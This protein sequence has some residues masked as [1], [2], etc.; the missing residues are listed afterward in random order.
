[1]FFQKNTALGLDNFFW[2]IQFKTFNIGCIQFNKI[3]IQL[4]NVTDL[5]NCMLASQVLRFVVFSSD[6]ESSHRF[7][8]RSSQGF[9]MRL[10]YEI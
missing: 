6:T 1:M 9:G 10:G 2:Q 8:K 7:G 4:E 3:V 5:T